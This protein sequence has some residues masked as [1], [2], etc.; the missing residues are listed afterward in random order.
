MIIDKAVIYLRSGK[1]GEGCSSVMKLS[2]RKMVAS[3]G[4]GGDGGDVI[5]RVSSHLYDLS[6]FRG[7]K[8]FI[9][10]NGD[11]GKGSNR[12][13]RDARDLIVELPLGTRVLVSG[14]T[15]KGVSGAI[16]SGTSEAVSLGTSEATSSGGKDKLIV[17]LAGEKTEFL[18]CRGG[19][20]GKG[21]YKRDYNLPAELGQEREVTL[22]YRIPNDVA[23]LGFANSGK[24][25]LFNVL[26]GQNR[27]VAEY[28]F[29]TSSCFW[30]NSEYEFKRFTVLDTP[31]F[32]RNKK[33]LELTENTFLRH[34]F[35]SKILLLLSDKKSFKEDFKDLENEISLYDSS[36]LKTKKIFYLLSKVDTIDRKAIGGRFLAI[37]VDRLEAVE[38]LK[39]KISQSLEGL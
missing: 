29:T 27:K 10:D 37:S 38:S 32:K 16:P 13:G 5:L 34:I 8:K 28:A 3:G 36:L 23:I 6:K 7:N 18:I 24:T 4:D 31:P 26:T 9:A 12:K 39:Q 11:T 22:D 21:N 20:G 1:G 25:A 35:R 33:P 19:R 14:A 30:S 15:P 17:D 2:S